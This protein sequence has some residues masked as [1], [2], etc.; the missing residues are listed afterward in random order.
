MSAAFFFL[1]NKHDYSKIT[2]TLL[3]FIAPTVFIIVLIYV[4][5]C[6]LCSVQEDAAASHSVPAVHHS[7]DRGNRHFLIR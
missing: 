6:Y 7:G 4:T 1:D 3:P 2:A 5:D